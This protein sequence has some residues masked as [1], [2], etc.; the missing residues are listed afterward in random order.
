MTTLDKYQCKIHHLKF[1]QTV[2]RKKGEPLLVGLHTNAIC[3]IIDDAINDFDEG[4]SSYIIITVPPRSGKSDIISKYLPAHFIANHPDKDVMVVSYNSSLAVSHSKFSRDLLETEEF[5]EI[6][7]KVKLSSKNSSSESWGVEGGVGVV[8]ASGLASG[9]TGKGY[10]LGILDDYCAGRKE[11]ESVAYRESTWNSFTNDFLTRQAPTNITII[12]ATPWHIDDVIGRIKAK[13]DKDNKDHYDPSFPKYRV[14]NFPAQNGEV[15]VINNL[16]EKEVVHYDYLFV[17]HTLS[18]GE[19]IK[20]RFTPAYYEAQHASLGDYGYQALYMC[21]PVRQGGN[22]IDT[23]KIKYHDNVKDFPLIKYWRVWDLAHSERQRMKDDPDWTSGTLLGF[24][25]NVD[26]LWELWI[27]DVARI[28]ADAMERNNFIYAV[29]EKDGQGVS[30][31]V[32]QSIDSKDAVLTMQEA[33][34]GKRVVRGLKLQGDKV[35]RMSFVE[36]IFE[37]GNVHV[38]RGAWNLDWLNEVKEFPSGKHDDQVDNMSAG[39]SLMCQ[40]QGSAVAGGVSGF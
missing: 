26:G 35:S 25:K 19:V 24:K 38:L 8:T 37:I 18:T 23:S 32:E 36:P 2:W 12:L 40:T 7:P 3:K 13:N 27:K 5:K 33:L 16:G 4:I 39:Y 10:H 34:K 17:D 22:L 29:S 14:I 30:I 31:A 21:N 1:M 9:I 6:Y 28:R 11:A 20:G 15:E